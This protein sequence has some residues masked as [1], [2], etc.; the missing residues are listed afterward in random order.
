MTYTN[1]K[2][3]IFTRLQLAKT[4]IFMT[5]GQSPKS[6]MKVKVKLINDMICCSITGWSGDEESWSSDEW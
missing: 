1:K 2:K 3:I 5:Q 4:T 6:F